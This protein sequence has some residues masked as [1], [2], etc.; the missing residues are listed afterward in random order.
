[1]EENRDDDDPDIILSFSHKK[2][3]AIG[4]TMEAFSKEITTQI[5][6]VSASLQA[7]FNRKHGEVSG[8]SNYIPSKKNLSS[9]VI[10]NVSVAS[11][12]I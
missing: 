10:T 11:T 9:N 2:D 12:V 7:L 4:D 6:D 3:G 5:L 1:M 8:E